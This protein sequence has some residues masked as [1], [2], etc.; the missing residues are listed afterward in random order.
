MRQ[1]LNVF[2]GLA[3]VNSLVEGKNGKMIQLASRREEDGN[4]S[5]LMGK[6]GPCLVKSGIRGFGKDMV[7]FLK[8]KKVRSSQNRAKWSI[9]RN[10]LQMYDEVYDATVVAGVARKLDFPIWVKHHGIETSEAD[11]FGRMAT[12]T[13][14]RPDNVI[15]VD[16]VGC[17]TSQ[18]GDGAHGGE[19]KIVGKDTVPQESVTTNDNHFTVLGF[20]SASGEPI[21]CGIIIEGSKIRSDI[22]TG[23]DIFAKKTEKSQTRISFKRTLALINFFPV[24]QNV[25]TV[26]LKCHA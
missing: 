15:F 23:M 11:A 5:L 21:M 14:C 9:Y 3:F 16:E 13:L 6:R 18:E 19:R 8:R 25:L 17:N 7:T 2:E 24:D 1:P 12:H 20:T 10:F 26:G 4:N 22:V